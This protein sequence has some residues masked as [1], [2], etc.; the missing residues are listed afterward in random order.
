MAQYEIG[1]RRLRSN[2]QVRELTNE[3]LLSHRQFIQPLFVSELIENKTP[4]ESLAG[5]CL[6]TATSIPDQIDRDLGNG[7]DKFLLFPIVKKQ[8]SE[9]ISFDFVCDVLKKVKDAYG[10]QVWLA[11]DVCL[12]AYTTHGHCGLLNEDRSAIAN[13]R[14]VKLL[15]RY[16]GLLADAG[17]DCIAPS[18]KMD[19]T[20]GAIRSQ[21]NDLGFFDTT[22]LSYSAKFTSSFY[23]PFRDVCDSRPDDSIVLQGRESYQLSGASPSSAIRSVLSDVEQG[24]DMIMVK[25]AMTYLD[26]IRTVSAKIDL[27][28]VAY[29]V[30]GEYQAIELLAQNG[31]LGRKEGHLEAWTAMKRSGADVI[32]SYAA[33]NARNWIG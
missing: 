31:L 27:P 1:S 28:V 9:K 33:R 5:V 18:D 24:A 6:H 11:T 8:E 20:V 12:C 14:T 22:I 17:A 3:V 4:A 23:G 2:R 15:A 26:I 25:P 21:L 30:S 16:A 7:I 29:H 19:G 13:D 10:N 32:I